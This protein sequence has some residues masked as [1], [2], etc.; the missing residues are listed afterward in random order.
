MDVVWVLKQ[1][2]G[3]TVSLQIEDSVKTRTLVSSLCPIG[4]M[5]GLA[6]EGVTLSIR[7][8]DGDASKTQWICNPFP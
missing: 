8:H 4:F 7:E 3:G 2:R 5:G 6:K 1:Q